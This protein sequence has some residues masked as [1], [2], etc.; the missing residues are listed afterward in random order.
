MADPARAKNT[1]TDILSKTYLQDSCSAFSVLPLPTFSGMSMDIKI[2]SKIRMDYILLHVS[3]S[4]G[5]Q[6]H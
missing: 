5:G 3:I 2:H 1:W 6:E 4:N